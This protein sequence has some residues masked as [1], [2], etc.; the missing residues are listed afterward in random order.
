LGTYKFKKAAGEAKQAVLDAL[1]IGYRHI[2]TAFI[3]AGEETEK[4]V[5]EALELAMSTKSTMS[6]PI[7]RSEIF[8][9]TKQWRDYHGYEPTLKCLELSLERLKVE[10]VDLYLIHWPGPPA[11]SAKNG[12]EIHDMISLRSETWRAMEDLVYSGKCKS[13]GVSNFNIQHLEALRKTARIWPPVVNQIELHPYNPQT[14]LVEYCKTQGIKVEAY[15]SLGG[16][17]SGKK[18]WNVLGGKLV[19]RKEVIDIATKYEKT[20]AQVL[21]KW[22][23]QKGFIVIP[24]STKVD[25]LKENFDAIANTSWIL[26]ESDLIAMASISSGLDED[27]MREKTRLC[28]VRDPLKMLDFD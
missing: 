16:Q 9:T 10:Y 23:V 6:P 19:E 20:A 3:Y 11:N 17:D 27:V 4:E 18:T 7:S 8:L 21:L 12:N 26:D 28:W 24:K 14:D 1:N 2:D 5:G 25:H 13:I 15:A 22:A